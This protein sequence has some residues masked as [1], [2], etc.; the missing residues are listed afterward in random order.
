MIWF[1][2]NEKLYW[3]ELNFDKTWVVQMIEIFFKNLKH[4]DIKI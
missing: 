1:C 3:V 4:L 2:S